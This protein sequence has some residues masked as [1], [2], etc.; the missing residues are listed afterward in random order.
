MKNTAKLVTLALLFCTSAAFAQNTDTQAR[1]DRLVAA[2]KKEGKVVVIGPPDA[3]VRKDVPAAFKA[4]YGITV[5]YIGGRGTETSSKLS[6]ERSA[7]V[8]SVDI[9]F[10]GSDSMASTYYG[11]KFIA[12]LK[13]ELIDPEVTDPAK[14]KK[15]K[16]WFSDPEEIYVLRLFNTAGP[17]VFINTSQVKP[18]EL[19]SAQDL[20]DPKWKGKISGH[21]P[22]IS[23]SGIGQATRFYLQFGEDFIRKLYVDQQ[24]TIIRDRRQ[25]TDGVARGAH[26][27]ALDGEDE[28]LRRLKADGLPIEAIYKFHDMG[29]TVS[30]GIGQMA[31]MD[32]APNPNAAKLFANWIAS[33]EGLTVFS[34][35]RGEAPTRSDIDATAYL[36]AEIIPDPALSY[37]DVH[38]WVEAVAA[39][40][41]VMG[42]MQQMMRNQ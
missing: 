25:L 32:K 22:R 9:A 8:Y 27:I 40:K 20:L 23:G 42:I 34:R 5:E 19:K 41:K 21:D 7:G 35:A 31:L 4:K 1:W 3:Q 38:D 2:A 29:G 36:P 26:P 28:S 18:G 39:R 13:P 15:G 33:K 16:L 17:I 24:P 11:E 10:G 12:P 30:A 37:F 14:W 6:A